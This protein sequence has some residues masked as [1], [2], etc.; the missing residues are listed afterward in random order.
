MYKPNLASVTFAGVMMGK[1][2]DDYFV[3]KAKRPAVTEIVTKI[4]GMSR[5]VGRP[6]KANA[7][8]ATQRQQKRRAKLKGKT[9]AEWLAETVGADG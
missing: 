2:Y 6:K 8:T 1:L 7:L 3:K 5:K 9:D 4:A